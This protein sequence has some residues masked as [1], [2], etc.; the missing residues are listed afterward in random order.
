MGEIPDWKVDSESD[1]ETENPDDDDDDYEKF[2]DPEVM[3]QHKLAL[4]YQA[5]GQVGKAVK[6]L[7][8]VVVVEE[9]MLAE[10]HLG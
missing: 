2:G 7:E 4:A 3:L 10:E 6:L 1:D 5:D 8:H 9:K